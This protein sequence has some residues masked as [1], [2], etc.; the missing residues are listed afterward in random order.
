[1]SD[2]QISIDCCVVSIPL[3]RTLKY[4][5]WLKELIIEARGPESAQWPTTVGGFARK[6]EQACNLPRCVYLFAGYARLR[7]QVAFAYKAVME[8]NKTGEANPFDTGGAYVGRHAPFRGAKKDPTKQAVAVSRIKETKRPLHLWRDDFSDYLVKYFAGD[9]RNY[10]TGSPPSV[11]SIPSNAADAIPADFIENHKTKDRAAWSWEVRIHKRFSV[12]GDLV[13][14]SC[15]EDVL[16][17]FAHDQTDEDQIDAL[18]DMDLFLK[19]NPPILAD[20]F[21]DALNHE[22]LKWVQ[23]N[24]VNHDNI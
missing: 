11:T 12:F 6:V 10:M 1:M 18:P 22:M 14:W 8:Q 9:C 23:K 17:E 7:G 5:E 2:T 15:T 16:E 13:A 3:A 20:D 24:C 4:T 19:S 21:T